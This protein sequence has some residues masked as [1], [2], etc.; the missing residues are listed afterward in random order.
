MTAIA[1]D[2]GR[3]E[4]IWAQIERL[5][6]N[7]QAVD[8]DLP[9]RR[10][11]DFGQV[12]SSASSCPWTDNVA[13][14]VDYKTVGGHFDGVPTTGTLYYRDGRWQIFELSVQ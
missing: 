12:G 3:F 10:G 11:L 2:S 5:C 13:A 14:I 1:L 6:P 9:L 8:S 4:A 7:P